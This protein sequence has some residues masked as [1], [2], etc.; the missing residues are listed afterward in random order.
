MP[1]PS[2]ARVFADLGVYAGFKL[3]KK[4]PASDRM[5]I[6]PEPTFEEVV[7][8]GV[9]NPTRGT[10]NIERYSSGRFRQQRDFLSGRD[11]SNC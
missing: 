3:I 5:A 1:A 4:R 11:G 2:S 6:I 7:T 8:L 9:F 10:E